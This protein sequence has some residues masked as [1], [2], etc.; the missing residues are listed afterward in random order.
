MGFYLAMVAI[1][2]T[3]P[4]E[5]EG[6]TLHQGQ[7]VAIIGMGY[8]GLPLALNFVNAGYEVIGIDTDAEKIET[9]LAGQSY[10][11]HVQA[12]A[13]ADC[14][15]S[16]RFSATTDFAAIEGAADICICVPTPLKNDSEPDIGA[17]LA[18]G[19]SI[20]AHLQPN[21][22]V[23][24]ES[25]T[26]PGTTD[27]ELRQVLE[28]SGLIANKD[29]YLAYSPEREDPGNKDFSTRKIPKLV[30]ADT[31]EALERALA[32]YQGAIEDI[33]PMNSTR[34]AE[35]AKLT[36]NIFRAVNIALVNELKITFDKMGI[37]IWEVIDAAA[38]KPFGYMPFYP[39]AG[40]GGHC[41]P[42]DPF[43]LAWKARECG[44]ETKFIDLAGEINRNMPNYVLQRLTDRLQ[45]DGKILD[46]Y[47]IL[48]LG[49]AYK[50]NI[51]DVRE[52]PALVLMELLAS[53]GVAFDY[54]DPMISKIPHLHGHETLEGMVS[55]SLDA[56]SL[57]N[58]DCALIVTDHDNV[59]YHLV[60]K[61]SHLVV[62]TRNA[63]KHV[64]DRNN[65]IMA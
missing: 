4:V 41:I 7:V 12:V 54:H 62:D 5:T 28:A 20:A 40:W 8:V 56:V 17:V 19:H 49:V 27:T 3:Y 2:A 53:K 22:L 24:L 65:I 60:A 43:Y 33:V 57:A 38:T 63:M 59:D 50:K 30:A 47:K 15:A 11:R 21:H 34:A 18:S 6:L 13:V 51:D 32:L 35:A 44:V 36:E 39:G 31:P 23:V 58:Y 55:V 10:I 42:V 61:H 64:V 48:I 52:S 14:L 29:F 25:S 9:L 26:Y 45:A 1:S 46:G 16:G 37:N